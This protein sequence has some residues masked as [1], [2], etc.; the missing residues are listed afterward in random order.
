[1]VHVIISFTGPNIAD[2]YTFFTY[3]TLKNILNWK[4][5]FNTFETKGGRFAI[6]NP[7]K[8]Q[9]SPA[10]RGC[11]LPV[12]WNVK[13]LIGLESLRLAVSSGDFLLGD[14]DRFFGEGER[15]LEWDLE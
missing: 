2:F 14:L 13:N 12:E 3:I 4:N 8:T 15:D 9:T 11:F 10:S 1:M 6:K 5:K 7:K